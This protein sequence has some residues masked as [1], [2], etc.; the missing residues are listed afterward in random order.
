MT[1]S[2]FVNGSR[3]I[4]PISHGVRKDSFLIF[5]I[6]QMN[7]KCVNESVFKNS[8]E[9]TRD[10]FIGKY[11]EGS[12]TLII[13]I[14]NTTNET[15]V[16]YTYYIKTEKLSKFNIHSTNKNKCC[17]ERIYNLK[18]ILN[19]KMTDYIKQGL[20]PLCENYLLTDIFTLKTDKMTTNNFYEQK[21]R[22]SI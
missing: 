8:Q 11:I 9:I 17:T 3:I 5:F 19:G 2:S 7:I 6:R 15:K 10:V 18:Q 13:R 14:L 20:M 4:I 22:L 16:V 21:L 1:V 12:K